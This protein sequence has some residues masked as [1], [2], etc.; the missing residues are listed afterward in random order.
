MITISTTDLQNTLNYFDILKAKVQRLLDRKRSR[1]ES[2]ELKGDQMTPKEKKYCDEERELFAEITNLVGW[3]E[4]IIE[5]KDRQLE[6]L[7]RS[8]QVGQGASHRIITTE[9]SDYIRRQHDEIS[10]LILLLKQ[11]INPN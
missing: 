9:Q 2:L 3:T 8:E 6:D 1:V 11:K 4:K 10:T 5:V 7:F